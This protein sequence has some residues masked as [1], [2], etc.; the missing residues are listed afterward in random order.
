MNLSQDNFHK[1][2]KNKIL[3]WLFNIGVEMLWSRGIA[4][5]VY[6]SE[7]AEVV[8]H[9][10][11]MCILIAKTQD[12]VILYK[13]PDPFY[14]LQLEK[15]GFNIPHF[16]VLNSNEK[17]VT[18]AVLKN[19]DAMRQ[20]KELAHEG[21]AILVPFGVSHLEEELADICGLKI[22][23]VS[24]VMSIYLNNKI[25]T[26]YIAEK[27]GFA[28]IR[29][30]VCK[31]IQE[32]QNQYDEFCHDK[33][34]TV[35][36]KE[37]CN[38]SGKGL[39][40]VRQQKDLMK[41]IKCLNRLFEINENNKCIIELWHEVKK[42][43]NYQIYIGEGGNICV[44]SIKEQL[45]HGPIYYGS[46]QS[47]SVQQQLYQ[48]VEIGNKIGKY[49][50]NKGITGI[51]SIDALYDVEESVNYPLIEINPRLSLSTY[52][53]FLPSAFENKYVKSMYYRVRKRMLL[54]FEELVRLLIKEKI[55]FN[56]QEGVVIYVS[57]TLPNGERENGRIFALLVTCTE[58]K[59][60]Y[61]ED[62][63]RHVMKKKYLLI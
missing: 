32:I 4:K 38:T 30:K 27:L 57:G 10:E 42:D 58:E 49:L 41:Y 18:N 63:F 61:L 14:L 28:I 36:I 33:C 17:Y 12:Y 6:D 20:L 16:I 45:L 23:G 7:E 55:F 15:I 19:K 59:N 35:I 44:F 46:V 31:S 54:S 51:L 50:F 11:E 39:Y 25:E 47:P 2:T 53:S 22:F 3:V 56:G 34:K 48:Y 37:P 43:I 52:I 1:E 29:G 26:R 24:S 9:M 62:K 13:Q 5:S 40:L 60:L 21:N 8:N